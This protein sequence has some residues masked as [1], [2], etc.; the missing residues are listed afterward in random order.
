MPEK[1]ECMTK[2]YKTKDMITI[3]FF[4]IFIGAALTVALVMLTYVG[5][6]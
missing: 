1:K 3:Y 5:L 4:G 2:T 6:L